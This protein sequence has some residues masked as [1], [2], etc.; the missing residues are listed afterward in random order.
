M[1]IPINCSPYPGSVWL[2]TSLDIRAKW[3]PR[4]RVIQKRIWIL[5]TYYKSNLPTFLADKG[6]S[7]QTG[8]R[9]NP[10]IILSCHFWKLGK[11]TFDHVSICQ[12]Q[13]WSGWLKP[14]TLIEGSQ[15]S[16]TS[17]SLIKMVS[18][19]KIKHLELTYMVSSKLT[20]FPKK[21][22]SADATYPE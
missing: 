3:A 22:S 2:Q 1:Y 18:Q 10:S 12:H 4:F 14:I 7:K 16:S 15:H 17:P 5:K 6:K 21:C 11:Q 8:E 13:W 9:F 19:F 20:M